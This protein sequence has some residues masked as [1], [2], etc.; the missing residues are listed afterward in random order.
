MKFYLATRPETIFSVVQFGRLPDA[1]ASTDMKCFKEIDQCVASSTTVDHQTFIL[2]LDL[3]TPLKSGLVAYVGDKERGEFVVTA[4]I[5]PQWVSK[6]F[7]YSER[8]YKLVTNLFNKECPKPIEI[9]TELYPVR[10][11]LVARVY[12]FKALTFSE[13]KIVI[14]QGDILGSN[15]QTLINTVNC[16]GVMGKG[17][18]LAFKKRYPKMFAEYR[19]R[20]RK[21]DIQVGKPYLYK[22]DD[23]RWII[24]FPTKDHWRNKSRIE[25][26][27][28]GLRYLAEK[29]TEWGIT[30]LA[31]PPLGCGNGGLNWSEVYPLIEQY[32]RPFPIALEV[33]VPVANTKAAR[34]VASHD[35]SDFFM[36]H[37]DRPRKIGKIASGDGPGSSSVEV[38]GEIGLKL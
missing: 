14:K 2:E 3:P 7:V 5:E 21:G 19:K 25:Y 30:S 16:Q 12:P 27:R 9:K 24:N 11:I 29:I 22:V 18:A 13:K 26:I 4:Q 34:A 17:I 38:Q 20:C 32:L 8:G 31:V 6:I 23:R 15:A 1:S 36:A 28:D 33:Y 10:D 35:V 37:D